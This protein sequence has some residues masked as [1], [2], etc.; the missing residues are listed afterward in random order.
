ASDRMMLVT[1]IF[2]PGGR[3]F[4]GPR[5][6]EFRQRRPDDARSRGEGAGRAAASERG[7]GLDRGP[8]PGPG[9]SPEGLTVVELDRDVILTELVPSIAESHFASHD[10]TAYRLAIVAPDSDPPRVLYSS[11]GQ[12]TEEDIETPDAI[13]NLFSAP[14]RQPFGGRNRGPGTRTSL[15]AS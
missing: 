11:S 1:G 13:A 7:P 12:W 15:A 8:G 9:G 3:Q 6:D 4:G 5:P 14:R 10:E 2:R